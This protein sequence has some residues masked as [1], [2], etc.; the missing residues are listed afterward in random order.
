MEKAIDGLLKDF[1]RKLKR[2]NKKLPDGINQ[3]LEKALGP[4]FMDRIRVMGLKQKV[5]TVRVASA[6]LCQE[7]SNFYKTKLLKNLK[8]GP[9]GDKIRDIK[10]IL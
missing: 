3:D 9:A 6:P 10:F 5:L 8:E 4:R 1:E 7:L 2:D